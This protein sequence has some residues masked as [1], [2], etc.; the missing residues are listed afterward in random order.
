MDNGLDVIT[1]L[2]INCHPFYREELNFKDVKQEMLN[3][4]IFELELHCFRL[5]RFLFS[6]EKNRKIF[7]VLFPPKLL[8]IFIDI[9]NFVKNYLKYKNLAD[10]FNQIP[11]E[12]I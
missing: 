11:Q 5:L 12:D 2:L 1:K 7:K 9:G 6:I 8:G 3:D 10:S 4:A